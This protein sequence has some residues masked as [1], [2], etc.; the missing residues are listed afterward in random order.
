M[1]SWHRITP[2]ISRDQERRGWAASPSKGRAAAAFIRVGDGPAWSGKSPPEGLTANV[3]L[4]FINTHEHSNYLDDW[5][6]K[7]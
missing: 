4:G 7:M 1:G 5:G 6:K 2:S 3:S